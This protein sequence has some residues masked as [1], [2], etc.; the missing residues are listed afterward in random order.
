MTNLDYLRGFSKITISNVCKKVNLNSKNIYRQ[1]EDKLELVKKE[2]E[3][4]IAKLYIK[5]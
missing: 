4:E 5:E 1:K 2:I 3:S